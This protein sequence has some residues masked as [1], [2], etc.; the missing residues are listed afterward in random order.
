M[1]LPSA[2]TLVRQQEQLVPYEELAAAL[3]ARLA[4]EKEE[5]MTEV[6]TQVG[7]DAT[8]GVRLVSVLESLSSAAAVVAGASVWLAVRFQ[9]PQQAGA[10][11]YTAPSASR[12][13]WSQREP[14]QLH[15]I[16]AAD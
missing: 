5:A 13:E 9:W 11:A 3:A 14:H 10:P 12:F 1:V 8:R 16:P 7:T 2:I 6:Y 4:A 15:L